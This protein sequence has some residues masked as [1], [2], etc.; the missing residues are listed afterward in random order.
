MPND[1]RSE[2]A[3]RLASEL[4]FECSA[5]TNCHECP[6]HR[7]TIAKALSEYGALLLEDA[8]AEIE[9]DMCSCIWEPGSGCPGT[10]QGCRIAKWWQSRAAAERGRAR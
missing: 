9:S 4:G 10:C 6:R 5:D 1:K 2:I 7:K 8:A 3:E